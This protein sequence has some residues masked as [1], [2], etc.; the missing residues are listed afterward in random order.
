MVYNEGT[1]VETLSSEDELTDVLKQH[2]V[3][4]VFSYDPADEPSLKL[5]DEF[6]AAAES[7]KMEAFFAV[8]PTEKSSLPALLKYE[9]NRKVFSM[10]LSG[11][12]GREGGVTAADMMSF[13]D[14]HNHLLLNPIDKSNFRTL[15]RTGK[16]LVLAVVDYAQE[17]EAAALIVHL[18]EAASALDSHVAHSVV[19][20][21]MDGVKWKRFMSKFH[22]TVPSILVMDLSVN[23][24]YV[25][26]HGL[27]LKGVEAVVAGALEKSLHYEEVESHDA[28]LLQR[29]TR[30]MQKNYP[31]SVIICA[32]PLIFLVTSCAFPHPS[33][34]QKKKD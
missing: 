20:G 7:L 2:G 16:P 6:S 10:D 30:K 12:A 14:T 28:S 26:K 23:G 21:H 9:L 32:L 18:D 34:V 3:A 27:D 24:Y 22:A 19:F 15:G 13:I 29:I 31:W 33:S 8:M 17:E 25:A 11:S 1:S 4:F 5:L